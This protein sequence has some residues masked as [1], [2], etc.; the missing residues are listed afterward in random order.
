MGTNDDN[1]TEWT[2]EGRWEDTCA[3]IVYLEVWLAEFQG[4]VSKWSLRQ[5]LLHKLRHVQARSQPARC[6][7]GVWTWMGG[8]PG[9]PPPWTL[10]AWRHPPSEK[11]KNTP[12]L[13]HCLCDVI[14]IPSPRAGVIGPSR[15]CTLCIGLLKGGTK[16]L[17]GGT[18]SWG[19][20]TGGGGGGGVVRHGN[21]NIAWFGKDPESSFI[22]GNTR[23]NPIII[24]FLAMKFVNF[25]QTPQN[26]K[27]VVRFHGNDTISD[28]IWES[29]SLSPS[30]SLF[31]A[32]DGDPHSEFTTRVVSSLR[33]MVTRVGSSLRVMVTRV[34]S[35]LCSRAGGVSIKKAIF[36]CLQL[37]TK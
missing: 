24:Y 13:G 31:A 37:P 26:R 30:L 3:M 36:F 11:L 18:K 9:A 33:V 4:P 16:L 28:Q 10:S 5:D 20:A 29:H 6:V 32:G 17:K 12:P 21:L 14:H 8:T 19:W 7:W 22:W 1:A 25:R 35:S 2:H 23:W 15:S 27:V 34:G